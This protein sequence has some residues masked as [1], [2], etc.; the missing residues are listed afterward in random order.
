MHD[1]DGVHTQEPVKKSDY[2]TIKASKNYDAGVQASRNINHYL[3]KV[4]T[5]GINQQAMAQ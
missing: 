4:A 1:R 3:Y 2:E 5:T